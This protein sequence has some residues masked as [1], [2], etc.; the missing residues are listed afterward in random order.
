MTCQ[1]GFP[2]NSIRERCSWIRCDGIILRLAKALFFLLL[3]SPL[4]TNA[5]L[6][7]ITL[8]STQGIW[9]C[10]V[11]VDVLTTMKAPEIDVYNYALQGAF[12]GGARALSRAVTFPFDTVKTLEQ[13][14]SG[15]YRD[16]RPG[17]LDWS[18]MW[19]ECTDEETGGLYYWNSATNE[20]TW[21]KPEDF[22]DAAILSEEASDNYK[23][24]LLSMGYTENLVA[25]VLLECEGQ[26]SFDDIVSRLDELQKMDL[27]EEVTTQ[28]QDVEVLPSNGGESQTVDFVRKF[29]EEYEAFGGQAEHGEKD[30]DL[31]QDLITK[32]LLPLDTGGARTLF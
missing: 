5:L 20:T 30:V 22:D 14:D 19:Q 11:S 21:E 25:I 9:P 10:L 32:L 28:M 2:V 27:G 31:A 16:E 26:T 29:I 13:S 3:V 7:M 18:E 12:A 1:S 4:S 15:T 17:S 6:D 23:E 24:I 8:T